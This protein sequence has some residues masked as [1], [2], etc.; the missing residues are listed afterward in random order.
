MK[1][2]FFSEKFLKGTLIFLM[3][4]CALS[5]LAG[6]IYIIFSNGSGMPKEWIDQ[7]FKS[8]LIPGLI[9]FF[10]VGGSNLAAL[11]LIKRDWYYSMEAAMVAGF[12]LQIWT[13]TEI[14]II[15]Q[16]SWLQI[17]YFAIGTI[18]L[19]AAFILYG[20]KK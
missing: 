6:G 8:Y 14:S 3:A 11:I 9:L 15:K 5:A 20:R 18:I 10:V 1:Y 12:G 17:L 16:F 7:V 2:P 13:Y 19:I 4:F